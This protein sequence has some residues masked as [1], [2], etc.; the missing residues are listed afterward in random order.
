MNTS[1]ETPELNLL[2]G[3]HQTIIQNKVPSEEP[4]RLKSIDVFRGAIIV[5]MILVNAQFSHEESYRQFAHAAWNGWTFADTIYP[6]FL[7][8]VG[9][10]LTLSTASRVARG[11]DRSSLLA[12]ALR[13]SLLIFG[14]GVVIDYVIFPSHQFLFVGFADHLQL[15]GVLQKIAIC[16]LV[17]F[18]IY[19]WTGLRGVIIGI[20]GLNLLYLALLYFYPVPGCGPG[21]LALSCNFPGYLDEIVVDGFRWEETA[22]D[23]NGL[24][25]ILPAITSVLFGVLAGMF[26]QCDRRPQQWLLWLL[27]AGIILIASGEILSK[28]VPINKH[29]WT[30]SFAVFTAGLAATGLACSIWLVDGRPVRR[31][32]RPLEILGLNAIAAY[33]ISRLVVH[34]PK[35]HVAGKSLYADV[36]APV[37]SPPKASLLFAAL[38][39]AAVYLAVW[40]MDRRG[41]HLR[42]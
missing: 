39:V 33:L 30:T 8:I 28:W 21:S 25:S 22:F 20:I 6:S 10:S 36:L 38:V 40:F 42:L 12:H 27:G 15:T 1:V 37:A 5:A 4:S 32:F 29:L 35:V 13:R 11:Q 19:L 23:P 17:A 34:V 31:W 24:G 2:R 14:F 16:Y 41:W 3:N 18:N 26:L 9:V 7:F